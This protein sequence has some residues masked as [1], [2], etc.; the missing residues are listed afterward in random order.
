MVGNNE[1]E[2]PSYFSLEKVHAQKLKYK[3]ITGDFFIQGDIGMD[4][5]SLRVTLKIHFSTG[6]ICVGKYDLYL[7]SNRHDIG[8]TTSVFEDTPHELEHDI[9]NVMLLLDEHRDGLINQAAVYEKQSYVEPDLSHEQKTEILKFLS[10]PKLLDRLDKKLEQAGIITQSNIRLFLFLVASSYKNTNP[11]HVIVQG[12]SDMS[13]FPF[14]SL[15][16]EC[17]PTEA[18]LN[19]TKISAMSMYYLD[20]KIISNKLFFIHDINGLHEESLY[21]L[22]ELQGAK[23]IYNLRPLKNASVGNIKTT[24][25]EVKGKFASILFSKDVN[26]YYDVL[27]NCSI[28]ELPDNNEYTQSVVLYENKKRSG[29]IDA[30]LEYASRLFLQNIQRMLKPYE[31]INPYAHQLK[32]KTEG[33]TLKRLNTQFFSLVEHITIMHQYMRKV[34]EQGRLLVEWEDITY[35]AELYF[36][37][38]FLKVDELDISHR[39][40]YGQLKKY[41]TDNIPSNKFSQAEIRQAFGISKTHTYRFFHH[42][43]LNNYLHIVGGNSNRGYEYTVDFNDKGQKV[44]MSIKNDLI[45]QI[46]SIKKNMMEHQIYGKH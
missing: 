43:K 5:S 8:K 45:E 36:N 6:E 32:L 33:K 27:K 24:N 7:A 12:N 10:T 18:V 31:V 11:L 23:S 40:F 26:A 37:S 9:M 13:T 19:L 15:L 30:D 20:N 41:V 16:A 28:V 29:L 42:L 25:M 14:M 44:C 4:L 46:S 39:R 3:G 35:A 1:P 21:S 34:D 17:I 22:H 38:I 2:S